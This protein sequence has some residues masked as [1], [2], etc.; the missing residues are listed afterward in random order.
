ML[1]SIN[2]LAEATGLTVKYIHKCNAQLLPLY[3]KHTERGEHNSW[4]FEDGVLIQIYSRVKRLKDEGLSIGRIKRTLEKEMDYVKEEENNGKQEG[5]EDES[6]LDHPLVR[7]FAEL[8]DQR[9][10]DN[11]ET[12]E[13]L[14]SLTEE[15]A[16]LRNEL[17]LLPE[18][19]SVHDLHRTITVYEEKQ[20]ET[21]KIAEQWRERSQS[22]E[23]NLNKVSGHVT[24]IDNI[25]CE[26]KKTGWFRFMKKRRL[27][28]KLEDVL[29]L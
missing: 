25:L 6:P 2:D 4:L 16:L 28:K 10:A 27:L 26:I 9:V 12:Y 23:D 24:D 13:K 19:K 15:N 11:K 14:I 29:D 22:L 3:E 8:S 20:G 17:K 21:V 18:G 1:I 7:K 5:K